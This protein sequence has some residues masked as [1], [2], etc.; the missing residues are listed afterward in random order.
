MGDELNGDEIESIIEL[1]LTVLIMSFGILATLLM[2]KYLNAKIELVEHEDKIAITSELHELND[3]FYFTGY[4]A[5]MFGWHMDEMSTVA[6]HWLSNNSSSTMS[7]GKSPNRI[8][9]PSDDWVKI[10]VL[11][12]SGEY[13]SN[14]IVWR[15]RTIVGTGFAANKNVKK[16]IAALGDGYGLY[17][18]YR[19]IPQG[20]RTAMYHLELTGDYRQHDNLGPNL[21]TGGKSFSW[22]LAPTVH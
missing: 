14:F 21:N 16:T 6:L 4:Q 7:G 5:Y 2:S 18:L 15:N 13:R 19:G 3:P 22:V 10:S 11:D 9:I 12:D 8:D 20:T 1:I 17:N